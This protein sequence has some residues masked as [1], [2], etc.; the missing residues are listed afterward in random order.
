MKKVKRKFWFFENGDAQLRRR[1]WWWKCFLSQNVWKSPKMS[2]IWIISTRTNPIVVKVIVVM[3]RLPHIRFHKFF[4][5]DS[6]RI[7]ANDHQKEDVDNEDVERFEKETLDDWWCQFLLFG[8]LKD[9]IQNCLEGLPKRRCQ[10]SRRWGE[11]ECW[12][13]KER[14]LA[15]LR[16]EKKSSKFVYTPAMQS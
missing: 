3:F 4:V 10:Q 11:I 7:V 12:P 5:P 9:G 14:Y 1:K 6:T 2:H 8:V 15:S 13:V 16:Y